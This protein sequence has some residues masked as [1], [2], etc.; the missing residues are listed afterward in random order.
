[1][2]SAVG[3]AYWFST[4]PDPRF[5]YGYLFTF[6]AAL[7]CI[8]LEK[9]SNRQRNI[10]TLACAALFLFV[11]RPD[12][13]ERTSISVFHWPPIPSV[14]LLAQQNSQGITIYIPTGD[15]RSWAAPLP[16]S[17]FFDPALRCTIDKNGQ[18]QKFWL[19]PNEPQLPR[20]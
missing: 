7:F 10:A 11:L 18:F 15:D 19:D 20:P 4:A 6:A 12:S 8:A 16:A 3:I 2:V 9:A 14:P 5:G 13:N 1:L 17:P